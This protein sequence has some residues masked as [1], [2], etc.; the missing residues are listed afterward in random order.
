ML[1]V[2][3]KAMDAYWADPGSTEA[4]RLWAEALAESGDVRGE[5]VLL[6]LEGPAAE[7]RRLA[8]EKKLGGKLVGPAREHLREWRFGP[9][10]LVESARCEAA[11]L[12]EGVEAIGQLNPRLVLT[13]TSLKSKA[14]VEALAEASLE[15]IYCVDFTAFLGTHGGTQL[16]DATLRALVPALRGVRNLALS[17]R[18]YRKECFSPAALRDLGEGLEG[19]EFLLVDFYR[20]GEGPYEDPSRPRVPPVEE[21]AEAVAAGRGFAS[22]KALVFRGA[23]PEPL[24]RALPGLVT[25]ETPPFHTGPIEGPRDAR[26]IE[27]LKRG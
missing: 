9:T 6:C 2:L 21:Y 15:R 5:Y 27:A 3:T 11:R 14:A 18:G 23:D 26:G 22:L 13:V 25:L 12:A 19:L 4:L 24:R 8:M 10:G 1:D 17:C 16:S 20:A 7:P